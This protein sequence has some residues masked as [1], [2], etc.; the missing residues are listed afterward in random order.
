MRKVLF[1]GLLIISSLMYG[2][3]LYV[4]KDE[5]IE[6]YD[7]SAPL[8]PVKI[9]SVNTPG[10]LKV[11][12]GSKYL[13]VLRPTSLEILDENLRSVKTMELNR[14]A[15]DAVL[16]RDLYVVHDYSITVF[17]ESLN[18]KASYTLNEKISTVAVYSDLL[19]TLAGGKIVAF[20]ANFKRIWEIAAPDP[21]NNFQI[22]GS[23]L[24]FSTKKEFYIMNISEKVPVLESKH[25]FTLDFK[26]IFLARN[27]LVVLSTN[28]SLLLL[29]RADMSLLDRLNVSAVS[30]A[31]HGDY[32]YI[33]T[34]KGGLTVANVLPSSIK[35]LQT[36]TNNVKYATVLGID[37][38]KL[39]SSTQA[40][41]QAAPPASTT[42]EK[43]RTRLLNFLG[44]VKFPQKIS[45]SPAIGKELYL[46][47]LDGSL[48]KVDPGSL[49]VQSSKVAFILTAD[50]VLL[51][52]GSIVLGSWDKSIYVLSDRTKKIPVE[53]NVSIAAART[54]QAFVAVDD[55][56]TMYIFES[57]TDDIVK[58]VRLTGWLVCPPAVHED[59]G[60]LVLDWLGMLHLVDFSGKE[61]WSVVTEACKSAEIVL[62]DELVFVIGEK[63]VWC[64]RIKDGKIAWSKTFG[65]SLVQGVSD[66]KTLYVCNDSGNVYALDLSGNVL[67]ARENLSARTILLTQSGLLAAGNVLYLLSTRDGSKI[68]EEPLPARVSGKMKMS[69]SGLLVLKTDNSLLLYEVDSSPSQGWPMYLKDWRNS[70]LLS[71]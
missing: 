10:V 67:W 16:M 27:N 2:A 57:T 70:S 8:L 33:I 19:I 22:V 3:T 37:L 1:V 23:S 47:S 30:V 66:G 6:L 50:P 34:S 38:M 9:A 18:P 14:K 32:L 52:D 56:G 65:A 40:Q 41:Q 5:S 62:T 63:T 68:L 58:K 4:V 48:L 20:D 11:L 29:S 36:V 21:V 17:D 28:G 24:M 51:D 44:E 39:T 61:V 71:K 55:N 53:S 15:V 42:Q 46:S 60:I 7:V 43:T 26:Q 69:D 45:T 13:Y 54:P 35:L 49:K 59:Y 64:V 25:K 12:P 31:N